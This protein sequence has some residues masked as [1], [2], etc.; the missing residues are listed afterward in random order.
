MVWVGL[1]WPINFLSILTILGLGIFWVFIDFSDEYIFE[2]SGLYNFPGYSDIFYK[3]LILL[4][5]IILG[6]FGLL[7]Y[8]L[9]FR[10][11]F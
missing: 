7:E 2:F 6:V 10:V 8:L 1:D 4:D 9:S 5:L 11:Y 3:F